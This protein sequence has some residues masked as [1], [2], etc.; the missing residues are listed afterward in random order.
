MLE[1]LDEKL[2]SDL[3]VIFIYIR[4]KERL[5]KTLKKHSWDYWKRLAWELKIQFS[6][7]IY[8]T[9]YFQ[10][11]IQLF[12]QKVIVLKSNQYFKW[13]IYIT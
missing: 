8:L 7:E 3:L 11:L 4:L 5:E 2:S 12:Y 1:E 6:T 13:L 9:I 10:K